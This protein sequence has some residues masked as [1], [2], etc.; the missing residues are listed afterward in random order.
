MARARDI[1]CPCGHVWSTK[2]NPRTRVKCPACGD[3]LLA[4]AVENP[5]RGPA[6]RD[7]TGA[8]E[9]PGGGDGTDSPSLGQSPAPATGP[10]FERVGSPTVAD[11]PA[12]P[13]PAD[14]APPKST[15]AQE[16]GRRGGLSPRTRARMGR[17]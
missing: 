8:P 14:K 2:A 6:P 7:T 13:A 9:N 16:A 10:A 1:Q 12:P 4:P 11:A 17:R 15:P 5:W 3:Y